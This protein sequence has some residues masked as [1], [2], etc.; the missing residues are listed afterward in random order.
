MT[1]VALSLRDQAREISSLYR[2]LALCEFFKLEKPSYLGKSS[3]RQHRSRVALVE[4]SKDTGGAGE[5]DLPG[6]Q[7]P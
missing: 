1:L 6:S 4:E 5:M 2:L 3:Q 7:H